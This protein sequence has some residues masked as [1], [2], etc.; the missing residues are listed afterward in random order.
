MLVDDYD[1]ERTLDEEEDMEEG[2][3]REEE[4]DN[5]EKEQDMPIAQLL[6]MYGGY[7]PEEGEGEV[8]DQANGERGTSRRVN[9]RENNNEGAVENEAEVENETEEP[10]EPE[11]ISSRSSTSEENLNNHDKI[12]RNTKDTKQQTIGSKRSCLLSRRL[13][14]TQTLK[15]VDLKRG[16]AVEN[17]SSIIQ[18]EVR[19]LQT[20]LFLASRQE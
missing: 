8:E 13:L 11:V 19:E 4:I 12:Q 9:V 16:V 17:Q 1:D 3:D 20:D 10:E 6:A 5:L 15:D 14:T 7:P 2:T 18:L